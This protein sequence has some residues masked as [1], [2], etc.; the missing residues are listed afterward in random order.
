TKLTC[1]GHV[2]GNSI[3]EPRVLGAYVRILADNGG[4]M[5]D[6][7]WGTWD[8]SLPFTETFTGLFHSATAN[9]PIYRVEISLPFVHLCPGRYWVQYNVDQNDIRP[10]NGANNANYFSQIATP[11]PPDGNG[12]QMNVFTNQ[13]FSLL[14][15][16]PAFAIDGFSFPGCTPAGDFTGDG[17]CNPDDAPE[18]IERL[19]E[20]NYNGCV[21]VNADCEM[22]GLDVQA[23]VNACLS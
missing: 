17:Q 14:N 19:L 11:M 13:T 5:G 6:V 21:D 12:L 8:E 16:A 2:S 22:N 1:Y 10:D 20:G 15:N 7:V 4:V 9:R 18:F 3:N 23:F